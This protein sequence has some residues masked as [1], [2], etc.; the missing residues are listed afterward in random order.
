MIIIFMLQNDVDKV[1]QNM[2]A[3]KYGGTK[4]CSFAQNFATLHLLCRFH[5]I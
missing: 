3:S 2:I 4:I 1:T 5:F